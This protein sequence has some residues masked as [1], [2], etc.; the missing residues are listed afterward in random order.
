MVVGAGNVYLAEA[1]RQ[2]FGTV[3]IDLLAG[4]TE[5]MVITDDT[6][7]P[8]VVAADLL[9]QAEHGL[10]SPTILVTTSEDVARATVQEVKRWLGIWPTAAIASVAWAGYGT[11]IL[12]SDD[13]E[14]VEVSNDIAPEHLEVHT[15]DPDWFV[16]RLRNYGPCSSGVTPSSHTRTRPSGPTTFSPP[17]VPPD[18]R[19]ACGSANSSRR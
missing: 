2:L 12:C 6:A 10:T 7:D 18:I 9:G 16:E 1:K 8:S 3:G 4:P 5:V 14:M 11:I 19:A 15:A 17:S 13:A